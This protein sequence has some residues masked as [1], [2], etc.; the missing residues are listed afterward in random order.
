MF[1]GLVEEVGTVIRY[2][3]GGRLRRFVVRA[4]R[5]LEDLKAGDSISVNGACQTVTGISSGTFTFESV[6]ETLRRTT[7][8]SLTAGSPVNLERALRLGDRLGGHLLLGHVDAVGEV[9][10]RVDEPG[11]VMLTVRAPEKLSKYISEKGSIGVD[12]VSLTVVSVS[13]AIFSVSLIPYTLKCTTL[14]NIRPGSRVNIEVD[15]LARYLE[16][17]LSRTEGGITES[18]LRELGFL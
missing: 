9:I 18:R 17:L 3:T 2:E 10:N 11:N 5:V 6:E 13:G 16:R 12:G 1:T 15:M 8:G 7:L 4:D 14:G